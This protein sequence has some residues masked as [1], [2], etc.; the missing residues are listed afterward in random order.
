MA[1]TDYDWLYPR[2]AFLQVGGLGRGAATCKVFTVS[3][4]KK[5]NN[6][7]NINEMKNYRV[8]NRV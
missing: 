6:N 3:I 5:K 2:D 8:I 4:R 7:N 1:A